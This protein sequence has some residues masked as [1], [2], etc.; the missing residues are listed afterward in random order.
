MPIR[1]PEDDLADEPC[2]E[3]PNVG[4]TRRQMPAPGEPG[5]RIVCPECGT[6]YEEQSAGIDADKR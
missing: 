4:L 5:F 6:V 1:E 3:C 2:A